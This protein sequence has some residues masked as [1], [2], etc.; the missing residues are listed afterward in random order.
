MKINVD[1]FRQAVENRD[2]E[3]LIETFDGFI[4]KNAHNLAKIMAQTSSSMDAA[5][6]Y[7]TGVV[8]AIEALDKFEFKKDEDIHNYGNFVTLITRSIT[9]RMIDEKNANYLPIKIPSMYAKKL[10]QIG[11]LTKIVGSKSRAEEFANKHLGVTRKT[12]NTLINLTQSKFVPINYESEFE[13]DK[14]F[15][16][17]IND[18]YSRFITHDIINKVLKNKLMINIFTLF[19]IDNCDIIQISKELGIT[20]PV[21]KSYLVEGIKRLREEFKCHTKVSQSLVSQGK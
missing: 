2:I 18:D 20:K 1:N 19:F 11:D 15:D 12:A 4:K 10:R 9:N 16:I 13:E 5:D 8:A 14:E 7:N 6:F 3:S 21:I 17:E